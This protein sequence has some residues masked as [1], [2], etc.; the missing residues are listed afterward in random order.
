MRW[1][2]SYKSL[3]ELA[4]LPDAERRQVWERAGRRA[5]RRPVVWLAVLGQA[6]V[7]LVGSLAVAPMIRSGVPIW[8]SALAASAIGAGATLALVQVALHAARQYLFRELLGRCRGCG[9]DLTGNASGVCP[10]CGTAATS[11]G[12]A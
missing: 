8:V 4:G 1:H 10:E 11:K 6:A 9:Y 5:F 2:W 3:P 12:D 7:V